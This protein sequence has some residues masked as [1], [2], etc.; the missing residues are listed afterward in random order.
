MVRPSGFGS[1]RGRGGR[2]SDEDRSGF[3]REEEH[4]AP[5]GI[6]TQGL[7]IRSLTLYPAEL[8]AHS[9]GND[10]KMGWAKG[11]EPSTTGATILCSTS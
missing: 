5:V 7:Q 10:E 11:L 6:R 4:G 3:V 2:C 9:K 8:R 1:R